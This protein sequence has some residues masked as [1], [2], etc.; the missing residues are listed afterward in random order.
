MI[1]FTANYVTDA[2]IQKTYDKLHPNKNVTIVQL[3]PESKSDL[4]MLRDLNYTWNS[5]ILP[6][7]FN[8]FKEAYSNPKDDNLEK[9]YAL[10]TQN[11][12]FKNICPEYILGVVQV[13]EN[14]DS[15]YVEIEYLEVDPDQQ[16]GADYRKYKNIGKTL[17]T[18]VMNLFDKNKDVSVYALEN[19]KP[20]YLSLG[21]KPIGEHEMRYSHN[22]YHERKLSLSA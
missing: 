11:K 13:K 2:T 10:T 14:T 3:D 16:Y 19:A 18:S 5:E 6:D 21:Y 22:D 7:L 17:L 15:D 4:K 9:Y 12:N 8:C 20:F 1:S